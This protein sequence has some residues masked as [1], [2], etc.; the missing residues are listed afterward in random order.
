MRGEIISFTSSKNKR[1]TQELK[2]L[3]SQIKKNE[4]EFYLN[5][6]PEKL[7]NLN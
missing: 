6:D 3:E 4:T 2:T 5:N 1:F 7:H